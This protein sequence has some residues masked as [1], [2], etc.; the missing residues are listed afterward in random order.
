MS[1]D[2]LMPVNMSAIDSGRI[3]KTYPHAVKQ[4]LSDCMGLIFEK[5]CQDYLLRDYASVFGKGTACHYYIFS[6]GGF[7]EGLREAQTSGEVRLATLQTLYQS[8]NRQGCC[9]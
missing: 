2:L 4:Y 8:I 3:A 1:V 7:T 9:M 5:I 6:K